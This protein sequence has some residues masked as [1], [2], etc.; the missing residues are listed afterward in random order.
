MPTFTLIISDK[1]FSHDD[2]GSAPFIETV[3]HG[4]NGQ[5]ST[6]AIEAFKRCLDAISGDAASLNRDLRKTLS[7]FWESIG[8][9]LETR[10]DDDDA[11]DASWFSVAKAFRCAGLRL[12]PDYS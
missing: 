2:R 4:V 8:D 1:P 5:R 3:E 12:S 9:A 11:N 10:N 7:D 6:P